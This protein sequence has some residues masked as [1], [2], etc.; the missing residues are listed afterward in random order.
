MKKLP[1]AVSRQLGYY[2]YLYI[3]PFDGKVFYV[4]KGR[5]NRVYSHLDADTESSK[6]KIIQELREQGKEAKIEILVHGLESDEDALRIEAA[7]IDLIGVHELSN[8]IRGYRSKAVGRAALTEL[9][10]LYQS[11][12]ALLDEPVILIR[13]NRLYRYDLTELELYEATRG[14]WVTGKRREK[15]TFAF[16]IFRNTVREVY[17][18]VE[19][20]PAGTTM[21]HTRDKEEICRE[22]RW[23]FIGRIADQQ[24]QDKY[25]NKSVEEYFPL[26][27]QNPI[28][29]VN[30]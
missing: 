19:W 30:C 12:K 4:G 28:T 1:H 23:E 7:A 27:A 5:G 11:E 9:I 24:V 6:G 17:K 21:Y 16:S 22:R 10:A 15:A 29:Y 20:F 13:I 2:V 8:R 25:I 3:N 18:I 26:R 14:V